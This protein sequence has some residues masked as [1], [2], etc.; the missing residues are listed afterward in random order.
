MS[1]PTSEVQRALE[2]ILFLADEPLSGT[3][4]AQAVETGRREVIGLQK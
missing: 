3:V 1:E 4:L 2:A